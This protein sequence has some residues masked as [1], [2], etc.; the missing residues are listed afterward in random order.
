MG[1][2]MAD[3]KPPHGSTGRSL[4]FN[5]ETDQETDGRRIAEIP[6][7]PGALAYGETVEE[8]KARLTLWLST[9]SRTMS[10]DLATFRSRLTFHPFLHECLAKYEGKGCPA[11]SPAQGLGD[12]FPAGSDIKLQHP[13]RGT[14][15]FGFHDNEEIGPHMLARIAKHTGI[16]TGDL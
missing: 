7:V 1:T 16:E 3:R 10:R 6:E 5:F 13:V 15:M 4:Q 9:R 14:Y 8:A 12:H 2:D 11:R